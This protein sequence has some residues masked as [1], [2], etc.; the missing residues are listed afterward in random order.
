M[1]TTEIILGFL[2]GG[3]AGYIIFKVIEKNSRRE[4]EEK[5]REN[6]E[7]R[8]E[9]EEN[10]ENKLIVKFGKLA[11]GELEKIVKKDEEIKKA[12]RK[13][14]EHLETLVKDTQKA[15][16]Q[17]TT[18]WETDTKTLSSKLDDLTTS[19]TQ[20]AA[21]LSNPGEQ[22]S[23][24]EESLQL[25]LETA[26][27][28]EGVHFAMQPHEINEEGNTVI[29]DCYIYLPDDGV[30]VIDS[31]APIKNYKEAF[32]TDDTQIKEEKLKSHAQSFLEYAKSLKNKD[33]TSAVK[34][35]TPDHIFMFVPNVTTYLAAVE[36]MPDL[37]QKARA[38]GIS[39]C[40]PQMLY[41]ALKTVWIT[42][43]QKQIHDNLQEVQKLVY[44]FQNRARLFFGERF[45]PLGETLK[46]AV[47]AY[48]D[49][50]KTWDRGLRV[51]LDR[52]EKMLSVEPKKKTK[53]P[54]MIETMPSGT[55]TPTEK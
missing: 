18:E 4:N 52:I 11:T 10:F 31:K 33:Y 9:N 25:M 48:N 49:G 12:D 34:R 54:E 5:R 36:K 29:P 47:D 6:E 30:I 55:D 26:G 22:G 39:I 45:K 20:W 8:R 24:A 38:L 40:P 13:E 53:Q 7:K 21:A 14:K 35:K 2:I 23:L 16:E 37:D 1:L 42:W 43:Q 41:A 50:V 51:T 19:H 17:A 27:F 28:E 15:L 46:D 32:E 3:I 44:E